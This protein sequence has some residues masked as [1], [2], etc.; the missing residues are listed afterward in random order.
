MGRY[1]GPKHKLARRA[2]INILDKTSQ[3]L[4]KRL[5]IPPGFH[6]RR[7]G[8]RLSEYGMQL[9][10]KQKI[11][12]MYGLL[13]KQFKRLVSTAGKK[14]GDTGEILMSLL[15]T[16]LDNT[17]YRLG[18][19]RTRAMARQLVSHGHVLI[20]GK[21]VNIPSYS[22]KINDVISLSP[23]IKNTP[24]VSDLLKEKKVEVLPFLKRE[25]DLGKIVSIPKREDL[26][27]P[28]NLQ[29]IVEYYSR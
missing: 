29:L 3:S 12:A 10:E 2:G 11:K 16:R 23:K 15:E 20:N 5:N 22:V 6:G 4:M 13:E 1:T 14:K 19:T 24:L 21:K 17:V 9:R 27:T 8:R 28:F 25:G 26:Q 18:F 7:R